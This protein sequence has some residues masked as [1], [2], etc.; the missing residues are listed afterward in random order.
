MGEEECMLSCLLHQ[1]SDSMLLLKIQ[2]RGTDRAVFEV[3]LLDRGSEEM[4][5]SVVECLRFL[6]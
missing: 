6:F 4:G 2:T 3:D 5:H 1:S